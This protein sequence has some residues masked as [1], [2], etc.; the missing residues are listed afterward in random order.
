MRAAIFNG[1]RSISVGERPDPVLKEPT[2][3]IVRFVLAAVCGSDLWYY[4]GE[5]PF[6]PGPIGHEFIGVVEDVL[7]GS[8]HVIHLRKRSRAFIACTTTGAGTPSTTPIS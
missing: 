7:D 1:P 8:W 5:S 6:A 2:D 3:A 4:R